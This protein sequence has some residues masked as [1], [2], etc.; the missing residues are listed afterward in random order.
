MGLP[1]ARLESDLFRYGVRSIQADSAGVKIKDSSQGEFP[2]LT[3]DVTAFIDL[4]QRMGEFTARGDATLIE[5]PYNLYETRLDQVIW[6]MDR[7]EVILTQEK[8]LPEFQVDIGIDSLRTYGPVYVSKHPGQDSLHFTAPSALFNYKTRLLQASQVPFIAVADAY[9][10]PFEGEVG[11]GYQAT[12]NLLTNAKILASQDNRQHLIYD[13]SVA[14][15]GAKDYSGSGFYDYRDAFG[16]SYRIYFERI[17]VDTSIQSRST[18]IIDEDDPFKLSPYFDFQ[19]DVTLSASEP[20]LAFD[21]GTRIVHDCGIGRAWLRFTSVVDPKDITIP[22]PAQMR[23]TDLNNIYAGS[24]ITRDSTHIYSTFISGRKDYFD[25]NVTSA[26]GFLVYDPVRESYIIS[27]AQ[28][29]EDESWPGQYLRLETANCRVY[30]EGKI[31]LTV[32]YGLVK[33]VAAGNA[34]HKVVEDEF[35][36]RLI[37]GLDF[38]FSEDA[39]NVMGREIDELRNLDAADLGSPHYRLAM[40]DLLGREMA[41]DLER[42]LTLTGIY[43]E[44]PPQ[45]NHTIFFNDLPLKWNQESA[46]FRYNGPVGIGNIGDIQVNKKVEAYVEFV[47]RGSGDIFD[48]YLRAGDDAWYYIA[49]SPGGLQVLSSNRVFNDLVFN[50]KEGDRRV[51]GRIGEGSYVYSLAARRR[52]DL[53]IDRFLEYEE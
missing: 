33:M 47:E 53:F 31:D 40:K 46:S 7:D 16:N 26:S 30:G 43:E 37:L 2:F 11:I 35:E 29:I 4:D 15:E 17:W 12:M 27:Q 50:L 23:N 42:Q 28:K 19:G 41:N 52:L 36:I 48:I 8:P 14:V 10:F 3:N 6:N 18:G 34:V 49:Y 51:R 32:D 13:A 1:E 20:F 39:L 5:F 45:W 24:L 22:I 25:A 21:G 9:V 44:I 38:F